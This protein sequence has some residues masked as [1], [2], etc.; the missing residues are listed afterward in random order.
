MNGSIGR[1][2]ARRVNSSSSGGMQDT[3]MTLPRAPDT[4]LDPAQ[5]HPAPSRTQVAPPVETAS[6]LGT[7]S[8]C[9]G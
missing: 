4:L 2:G 5:H 3:I 1:Q 6:S 8:A 9:R 7:P